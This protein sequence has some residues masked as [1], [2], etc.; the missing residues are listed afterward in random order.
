MPVVVVSVVDERARGLEEGA[1]EYLIKPVSRDALV[2][3]L[4]R[5]GPA[6]MSQPHTEGAT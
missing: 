6:A 4:A 5:A 1:T 3:A 2:G